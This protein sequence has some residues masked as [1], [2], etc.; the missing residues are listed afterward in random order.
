LGELG[1]VVGDRLGDLLLHTRV[2]I[3][4]VV[5]HD[6][7]GTVGDR[8]QIP[9]GVEVDH[10]TTH[11]LVVRSGGDDRY[12]CAVGVLDGERVGQRLARVR[13]RGDFVTGNEVV[14]RAGHDL[15]AA[16]GH[17]GVDTVELGGD[18]F[19]VGDVL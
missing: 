11:V 7:A 2:G 19:L 10:Q 18:R 16:T 4:G 12:L 9:V 8:D 15:V 5:D 3:D 13:M 14:V 6:R 17:H 1:H